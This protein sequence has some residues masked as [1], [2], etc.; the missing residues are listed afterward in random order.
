L[1]IAYCCVYLLGH[2]FVSLVASPNIVSWTAE[3]K[4]RK[5]TTSSSLS[6]SSDK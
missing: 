4:L 2:S 1:Q 6:S 3:C 5:P